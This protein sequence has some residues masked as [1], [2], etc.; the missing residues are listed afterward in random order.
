[1][2]FSCLVIEPVQIVDVCSFLLLLSLLLFSQFALKFAK[3]LSLP[4]QFFQA[5]FIFSQPLLFVAELKLF[6]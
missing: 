4:L 3:T 2:I 5:L 6:V 1:V